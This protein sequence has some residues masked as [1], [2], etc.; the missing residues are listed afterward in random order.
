MEMGSRIGLVDF[1]STPVSTHWLS[2]FCSKP[3]VFGQSLG[4]PLA[5][6]PEK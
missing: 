6:G 5:D 1:K 4:A 2:I 3:K